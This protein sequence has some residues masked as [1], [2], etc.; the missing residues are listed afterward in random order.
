MRCR[1]FDFAGNVSG[2]IDV[3]HRLHQVLLQQVSRSIVQEEIQRGFCG[4]AFLVGAC[5][6]R[7]IEEKRSGAG[8]RGVG[9]EGQGGE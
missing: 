1:E 6:G 8:I 3:F 4:L 2:E 7:E 9:G 5:G